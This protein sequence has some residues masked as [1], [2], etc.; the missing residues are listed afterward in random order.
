MRTISKNIKIMFVFIVL[1]TLLMSMTMISGMAGAADKPTYVFGTE[2]AWAPWDYRDKN[3]EEAGI[4]IEIIEAI[5]EVEGF[6]VEWKI[7]SW[8]SLIPALK[9]G[10]ID[11]TGGGMTITEERAAQVDFTD[12]YWTSKMVVL[13]HEDSNLNVL[14]ALSKGATVANQRGT[15]WSNWVRDRVNEG[16]DINQVLYSGQDEAEQ[17][18]VSGKADTTLEDMSSAGPVVEALPLK[19]IATFPTDQKYGYAVQK[20]NTE[21][22]NM[23][24][25]GLKKIQESGKFNQIVNKYM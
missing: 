12:P 23:L 8:D 14:T 3:G 15:T 13:V 6:N 1:S 21:L 11:M 2:L 25:D 16:F 4:D 10:K 22:L 18:V 7:L 9:L 17:A 24:N 20:G 19:I 5:A